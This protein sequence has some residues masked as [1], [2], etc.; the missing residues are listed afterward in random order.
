MTCPLITVMASEHIVGLSETAYVVTTALSL[1]WGYDLRPISSDSKRAFIASTP[2]G[3]MCIERKNMPLA[4]VGGRS[5]SGNGSHRHCVLDRIDGTGGRLAS[6]HN[7]QLE[8]RFIFCW[9]IGSG[10]SCDVLPMHT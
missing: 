7:R 10:R 6:D 9:S 3:A 8:G 4:S 2:P 1:D 5:R